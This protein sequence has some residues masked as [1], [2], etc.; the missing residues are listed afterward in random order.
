MQ[1]PTDVY[2]AAIEQ[3]GVQTILGSLAREVDAARALVSVAPDVLTWPQ[4]AELIESLTL[5]RSLLADAQARAGDA[6]GRIES[7][8]QAAST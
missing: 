5:V 4:R 7:A 3:R 8:R 2:A 1:N 6:Q